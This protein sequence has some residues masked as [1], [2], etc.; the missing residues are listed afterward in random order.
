MKTLARVVCV[1]GCWLMACGTTSIV[2]TWRS[3]EHRGS[4]SFRSVVVIAAVKSP[5]TRRVMEDQLVKRLNVP[6]IASYRLAGRDSIYEHG[7]VDGPL[8]ELI[9][10]GRF[11][12]AIVM[13]LAAVD[14]ETSWVPGRWMGP[15]W[16]WR[17]WGMWD[18]GHYDTDTYVRMETN[19]YSLPDE[20]LIWAASSQTVNPANISQL[21]EATMDA[22]VSE[23]KKQG[24]LRGRRP[25]AARE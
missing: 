14:R 25:I 17:G 15:Y 10:D 22:V 6:A 1:T 5:A 12:G 19:V 4:L 3:P 9:R 11:D 20:Q 8:R 7:P 23:L 24:L 2:S 18:P 16:G 13:R 21:T